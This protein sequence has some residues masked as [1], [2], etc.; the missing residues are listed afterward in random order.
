MIGLYYDS[1]D[2]VRVP[3]VLYSTNATWT[4]LPKMLIYSDSLQGLE[5]AGR[6][7]LSTEMFMYQLAYVDYMSTPSIPHVLL[8]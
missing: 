3:V 1:R 8:I 2:L 5:A 6:G 7:Q 4:F